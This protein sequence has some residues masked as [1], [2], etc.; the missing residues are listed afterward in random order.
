MKI[1]NWHGPA[2]Q[3]MRE[4]LN[5]LSGFW[6]IFIP[7]WIGSQQ[8]N[9]I[10]SFVI[11]INSVF[12][13]P[14]NW[15]VPN[16]NLFYSMH[17]IKKYVNKHFPY[18]FNI[19]F[20]ATSQLKYVN[21]QHNRSDSNSFIDQNLLRYLYLLRWWNKKLDTD[22]KEK[23]PRWMWASFQTSV[24]GSFSRKSLKWNIWLM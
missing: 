19:P 7:F 11:V 18:H 23:W 2:Y 21:S 24:L 10:S 20:T 8:S 5:D 22:I 6:V 9:K 1:E 14:L 16:K 13:F 15:I 12:Y 17:G 4:T 3:K